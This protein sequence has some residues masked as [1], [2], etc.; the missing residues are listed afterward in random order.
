VPRAS[1]TPAKLKRR[2]KILKRAKGY[3]GA[4]HRLLRVAREAVNR[5]E[6]YAARDRRARKRDMRRLWITRVNAAVRERGM[7]YSRFIHVLKEAGVE[8]N[9]KALSELAIHDP[10]AFT[11]LVRA[12]QEAAAEKATA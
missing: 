3:W 2:K 6:E 7:T 4:R 1:N 8:M 12:A 5:A 10:P 11:E 9:R